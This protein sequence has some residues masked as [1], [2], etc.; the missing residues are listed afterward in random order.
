MQ[1]VLQSTRIK[2]PDIPKF[3]G[4]TDLFFKGRFS[5]SMIIPGSPGCKTP[6]YGSMLRRTGKLSLWKD[7]FP[8]RK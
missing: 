7:S 5:I 3:P 4:V 8:R 2:F 6:C 1:G